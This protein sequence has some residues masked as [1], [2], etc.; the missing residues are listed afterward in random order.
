MSQEALTPE[1]ETAVLHDMLPAKP[2]VISPHGRLDIKARYPNS[3]L[4]TAG[5]HGKLVDIDE[6]RADDEPISLIQIPANSKRICALGE[7]A[8]ERHVAL[9]RQ[10]RDGYGLTPMDQYAVMS[11]HAKTTGDLVAGNPDSYLLSINQPNLHEMTMDMLRKLADPETGHV[12]AGS[13]DIE[14][15][16]RQLESE[17]SD[18]SRLISQ[19]IA[20][21]GLTKGDLLE[22]REIANKC[23]NFEFSI[24]LAACAATRPANHVGES[25]KRPGAGPGLSGG[26]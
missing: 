23:E 5:P 17:T 6:I 19:I 11:E 26:M 8:E 25:K 13:P 7:N 4:L 14:Q 16:R 22:L 9:H 10:L 15:Y 24:R 3:L 21:T 18:I 2:I 20:S 12:L 1:F